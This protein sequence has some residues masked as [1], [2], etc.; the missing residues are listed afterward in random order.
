DVLAIAEQDAARTDKVL[1]GLD[2]RWLERV[3]LGHY[4]LGHGLDRP[5]LVGRFRPDLDAVGCELLDAGALAL[6]YLLADR[7]TRAVLDRYCHHAPVDLVVEHSLEEL[8]LGRDLEEPLRALGD[9]LH[10]R[11]VGWRIARRRDFREGCRSGR[12]RR[13]QRRSWRQ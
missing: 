11:H 9:A 13:R 7:T 8:A 10:V 2:L 1:H 6:L 3:G 12:W 4:F 5:D